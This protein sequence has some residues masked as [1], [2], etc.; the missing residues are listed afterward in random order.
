M[1]NEQIKK[2]AAMRDQKA[3]DHLSQYAPLW[4]VDEKPIPSEDALQ[5]NVIFLH[6][7]YGWVNRR[8]RYDAYTDVLYH[9]GQTTVDEDEALAVQEKTPY[10]LAPATNTVDSYGG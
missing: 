2:I 9:K 5:F 6:P 1:S 4:L 10:L 7:R 8:Y 3:K